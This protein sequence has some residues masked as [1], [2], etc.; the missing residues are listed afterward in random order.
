MAVTTA[1]EYWLYHIIMMKNS[2]DA[3]E[4]GPPS[5]LENDRCVAH[6]ERTDI[7]LVGPARVLLVAT[8]G[9]LQA[10]YHPRATNCQKSGRQLLIGLE[11]LVNLKVG[12]LLDTPS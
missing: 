5:D 1:I 9:R 8:T 7:D 12:S 11:P 6:V 4:M 10:A 2:S 3:I